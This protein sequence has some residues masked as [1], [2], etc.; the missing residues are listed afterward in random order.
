MTEKVV[1]LYNEM[2]MGN[3]NEFIYPQVSFLRG[4]LELKSNGW[5]VQFVG[6]F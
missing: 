3:L 1:Y 6:H 4:A 2:D 5:T